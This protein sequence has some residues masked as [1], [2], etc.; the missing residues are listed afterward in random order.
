MYSGIIKSFL[1]DYPDT[2]YA[3]FFRLVYYYEL[4]YIENII[5]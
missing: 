3:L 4:L 5:L 2:L 1:R